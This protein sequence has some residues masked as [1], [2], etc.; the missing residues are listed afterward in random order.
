MA[1][2]IS[3]ALV[4][5][6]VDVIVRFLISSHV[7]D[8]MLN[9][10]FR[11]RFCRVFSCDSRHRTPAVDFPLVVA[12]GIA[13]GRL[14]LVVAVVVLQAVLYIVVIPVVFVAAVGFFVLVDST[15]C[16]ESFIFSV[17]RLL[18]VV[19]FVTTWS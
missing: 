17:V 19:L 9:F 8:E 14:C 13:V 15:T 5:K 1:A 12:R 6:L 4:T 16:L 7:V 2:L 10:G 18:V 3:V 11:Q